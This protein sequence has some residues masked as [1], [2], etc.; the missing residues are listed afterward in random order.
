MFLGALFPAAPIGSL[1]KGCQQCTGHDWAGTGD[2]AQQGAQTQLQVAAWGAQGRLAER[3]RPG[4][5]WLLGT[6]HA[7]LISASN[8]CPWEAGQQGPLG[9]GS[10]QGRGAAGH[11]AGSGSELGTVTHMQ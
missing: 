9:G 8:Q 6:G 4:A 5:E 7:P 10:W 3:K 1:R 11:W 2:P